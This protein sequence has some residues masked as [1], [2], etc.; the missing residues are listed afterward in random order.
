MQQQVN[1]LAV[2]ASTGK[3][4]LASECAAPSE[5]G[6]AKGHFLCV[7]CGAPVL[8]RRGGQRAWHFAHYCAR[9]SRSCP[10]Q[11]GGESVAHYRAKHFLARNLWRCAF[12]AERCYGCGRAAFFRARLADGRCVSF[13][14]CA[15]EVERRIAGTR[16]VA[17]VAVLDRATGA[18][19]AALEVL[20]TH[21]VDAEKRRAC[22]QQGVPVLEVT[23][24]EV[25][26]VQAR[27]PGAARLEFDTTGTRHRLCVQCLLEHE[28]AMDALAQQRVW[29]AHDRLW[30]E[31]GEA[32]LA[33]HRE[34]ARLRLQEL[35]AAVR[36]DD[37]ARVPSREGWYNSLWEAHCSRAQLRAGLARAE[38]A[39][40]QAIARGM[41][42]AQR[43]LHAAAGS[44]R[45]RSGRD[46][47]GKCKG[48][49]EWMFEWDDGDLCILK[50]S[51][52]SEPSW[53]RLF[54][55]DDER[56]RKR[57]RKYDREKRAEAYNTLLV[58]DGCAMQCVGCGRGCL[59]AH[60]AKYGVCYKCNAALREEVHAARAELGR[61]ELLL[62]QQ[63]GC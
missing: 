4:V 41:D 56:F 35:Y 25:E 3:R 28:H 61:A 54:D 21:A 59:L 33:R 8:V 53:D 34:R 60:L 20:H 1:E 42:E 51:C 43:L 47:R 52:M 6:Y 63:G 45:R 40:R 48:C 2:L 58:H 7:D 18:Q 37:F 46:C 23:T 12:A 14:E 13:G 36:S 50:A 32:A 44:K 16:C 30:A 24:G 19:V 27:C 17:D 62:M 38:Q 5:H 39:R 57:Y 55:G 31:F 9:D 49:G 26:R 11:N 29:G 22:A 15:A 10:R